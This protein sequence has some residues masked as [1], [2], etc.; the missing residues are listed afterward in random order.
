MRTFQRI[1]RLIRPAIGL[2][3]LSALALI[4]LLVVVLGCGQSREPAAASAP[5]LAPRI[6]DV[7]VPATFKFDVNESM[8]RQTGDLRFVRH[9]YRGMAPMRQVAEFYRR[10]MAGA[11][12]KKVEESFSRGRRRFQ[13]EKADEACY[14]S[15][16]DDWGTKL[17]IQVFPKGGRPPESER[18]SGE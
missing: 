3:V 13:F 2:P 8:D 18:G 17:L 1:A 9:L 15:V 12:W 7:P 11:G 16:W 10:E 5:A 14:I 4:G 6:S